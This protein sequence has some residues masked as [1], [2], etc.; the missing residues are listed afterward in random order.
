MVIGGGESTIRNGPLLAANRTASC[1]KIEN[2]ENYP[3][4]PVS[5]I[6]SSA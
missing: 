2:R 3:G 1:E 6:L 4:Q 5:R